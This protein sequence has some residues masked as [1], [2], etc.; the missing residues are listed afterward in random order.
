MIRAWPLVTTVAGWVAAG[1]EVTETVVV[2]GATPPKG[3]R[4]LTPR[5]FQVRAPGAWFDDLRATRI[6]TGPGPAWLLW[7]PR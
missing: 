1:V 4:A 2:P 7:P 3:F 5:R 6:P